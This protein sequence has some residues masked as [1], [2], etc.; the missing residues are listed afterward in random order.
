MSEK[1]VRSTL[2]RLLLYLAAAAAFWL[3]FRYAL[4]WTLPFLLAFLLAH[5]IQRP[6]RF[7]A[8]R[9]HLPRSLAAAL[10]TLLAVLL[11][12]AALSL[13]LARVLF[14][15]SA[16]SAQLPGLLEDL[17]ARTAGLRTWLERAALSLPEALRPA[18]ASLSEGLAGGGERLTI[19]AADSVLAL[20]SGAAAA[21]P[22]VSFFFFATAASTFF[23]AARY[24]ALVEGL[25]SRVPHRLR[26][27]VDATKGYVRRSLWRFLRGRGALALIL[28]GVLFLGLAL[29]GVDYP[30]LTAMVIAIIDLL[31][32]LGAGTV[33]LPWAAV[34]LLLGN[35]RL[36]VC[37][38][39]LY[40]LIA[41]VRGR[42][43]PRLVGEDLGLSPLATLIC[44]YVGL[45]AMGILGM[46]V[47][48]VAVIL[49]RNLNASGVVRL[50]PEGAD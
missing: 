27:G 12:F 49:L 48:P 24:D 7:L 16:L 32:L 4:R 41:W 42:L 13:I 47:L 25:L 35:V 44:L 8:L 45:K 21:L 22:D 34:D 31:P 5:V 9:L 30:L 38:L 14:E 37:L 19:L 29:L 17:S 50:W 28:C 20:V 2:M 15:L 6:V 36:A 18:A 11:F 26:G 46:I 43:W 1:Q 33:L 10:G 23:I 3:F 40:L 39:A